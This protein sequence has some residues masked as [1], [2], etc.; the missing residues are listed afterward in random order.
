M[1]NK[2]KRI[3]YIAEFLY[4]NYFKKNNLNESVVLKFKDSSFS[5]PFLSKFVSDG[6][7]KMFAYL[8]LLHDPN[9]HPLLCIEEPENYL[10]PDLL[11]ELCEEIREY[12]ERGGQV[13]VSTHSPDFVNGVN[14]DELHFLTKENGF[15]RIKAAIDDEQ[16]KELAADNQ[17][18]WL[19]RNHYING[20]NL[21]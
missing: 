10:H 12:S 14:I 21:K 5:A 4:D 3:N 9:P 2:N 8:I 7:I 20:A 17:L 15:S 13:L 18:G 19:W 16:V 11:L 6:T 1:Y